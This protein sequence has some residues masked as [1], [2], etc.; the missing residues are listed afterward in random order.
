MTEIYMAWG[1]SFIDSCSN[2]FMTQIRVNYSALM[3]KITIY[4][5]VCYN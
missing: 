2:Y 3:S 4:E 1:M 5:H